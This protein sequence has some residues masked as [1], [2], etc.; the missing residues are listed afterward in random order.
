MSEMR[1]WPWPGRRRN[2]APGE[3]QEAGGRGGVRAPAVPTDRRAGAARVAVAVVFFVTGM[4]FASWAAR[5]PAVEESLHLSP[6]GLAVALAGLNVGALVALPVAG[7]IVRR[8]GC[9]RA[10][11]VGAGV[12]LAALPLIPLAAGVPSL[13]AVLFLFAAGNSV[14]DVAMN[15]GGVLVERRYGKPVLGGFH[16][17]FS[18]GGLAG[19]LAGAGFAALGVPLL[20][21]FLIVAVVC[22]LLVMVALPRL[23]T[24]EPARDRTGQRRM[25]LRGLLLVGV[26]AFA[27]LMA[28]GVV[29]D[30]SAV[31]MR[32]ITGVGPGIAAM[33][34]AAFSLG[35]FAGRLAIDRVRAVVAPRRLISCCGAVSAL[36]ALAAVLFPQPGIGLA[37]YALTGIGVAGVVPVVFGYA[38]AGVDDSGPVLAA[39]ST[40][41]YVGFLAGPPIVGGLATVAGL[42]QAA[43]VLPLLGVLTA[44]LGRSLVAARRRDHDR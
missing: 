24:D 43:L 12:Y 11:A 30:W 38:A 17:M 44:G 23:P 4:V 25:P 14:L 5:V 16:A 35:M 29:N 10:L 37:G 3:D 41:G 33:A 8:I 13:A 20:S 21:H 42:R 40:L 9:R 6:G 2:R 15:T 27:A 32:D 18:L 1:S 22:G 36:S 26:V 19:A 34:F 39:V 31:F 7:G 28:E